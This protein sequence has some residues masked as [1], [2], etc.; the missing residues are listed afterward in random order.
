[1][2]LNK[3]YHFQAAC[4][5]SYVFFCCFLFV[6]SLP[7]IYSNIMQ[8]KN[9]LCSGKWWGGW[10]ALATNPKLYCILILHNV[11]TQ[12]ATCIIRAQITNVFVIA[13]LVPNQLAKIALP[14]RLFHILQG[15]FFN[16]KSKRYHQKYSLALTVE[17]LNQ[18]KL[19]MSRA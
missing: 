10:S 13:Q 2:N 16:F 4:P 3:R 11:V 12:L 15:E 9:F 7:F 14:D 18:Y 19:I 6:Y 17:V 8:K 5:L 1:M